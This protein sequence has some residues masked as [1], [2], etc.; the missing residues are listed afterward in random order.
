MSDGYYFVCRICS[1]DI[2][3]RDIEK[4]KIQETIFPIKT[5]EATTARSYTGLCEDCQ[6]NGEK[7]LE[8]LYGSLMVRTTRDR[9]KRVLMA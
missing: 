4:Y 7:K 3:S 8:K 1:H 6:I 9:I 2:R 5:S